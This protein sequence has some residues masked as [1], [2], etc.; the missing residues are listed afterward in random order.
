MLIRLTKLFCAMLAFLAVGTKAHAQDTTKVK[1]D[2]SSLMSQLEN[3]SG[4][5]NKIHYATRTFN[6]TRVLDG[7]SVENLPAH[8]L[9]FRIS[10]R[11]GPLK[12]GAF[13][14]LGLSD[15]RFNVRIGFDY[16]ITKYLT[17]GIGHSSFQATYDGFLKLKVLRQSGGDV[18]MPVSV[19]FVPTFALNTQRN[20][21]MLDTI[22]HL[23]NNGQLPQRDYFSYVLQLLIARKFSEGLSLQI[24]PTYVHADNVSFLHSDRDIWALG[25]AGKQE[26]T[27]KMSINAEY[28][29]RLSNAKSDANYNVFSFGI[30][31]GTGGHDFHL[32]FSNSIGLT[33]KSFI[34]ETVDKFVYKNMRFGF[35]ISRVLQLGKKHKSEAAGW[36]KEK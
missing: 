12:T 7:Q 10:H 9:D 18:N 25:I 22:Q 19:S 16:G 4:S 33:E 27:K 23:I 24:T 34:G 35:N 26:I 8:V 20:I 31:L 5:N 13:G 6:Y 28:Y 30:D 2:T 11:F 15:A 21:Q 36:K 1:K 29:Y 14:F 17:V 32:L 3:E